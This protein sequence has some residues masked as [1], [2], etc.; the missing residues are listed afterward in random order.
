MTSKTSSTVVISS[1]ITGGGITG[2]TVRCPRRLATITAGTQT[3]TCTSTDLLI[4]GKV[5]GTVVPPDT[6]ITATAVGSITVNNLLPLNAS[7]GANDVI[8][9]NRYELQ[10]TGSTVADSTNLQ[11]SYPVATTYVDVTNEPWYIEGYGIQ[12]GTYVTATVAPFSLTLSK[13]AGLTVGSAGS[14][15]T[16]RLYRP[17]R[18]KGLSFALAGTHYAGTT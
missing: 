6:Y 1:A 5:E 8:E 7:G 2:Y 16:Y 9:I 11:M 10:V 4:G 3:I 18:W 13:A 12:P 17:S 15:G 14:G